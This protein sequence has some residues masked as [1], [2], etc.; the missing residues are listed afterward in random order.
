[1]IYCLAAWAFKNVRDFEQAKKSVED[2][3]KALT[4][5]ERFDKGK[6]LVGEVYWKLMKALVQM[7]QNNFGPAMELCG[8]VVHQGDKLSMYHI[9]V[10]AYFLAVEIDI[11][12]DYDRNTGHS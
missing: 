12:V 4:Q 9:V 11:A 1:M 10:E 2:V 3:S 5:L 6:F 7:Q 8:E